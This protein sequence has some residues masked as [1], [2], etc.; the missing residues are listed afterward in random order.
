MVVTVP[1]VVTVAVVVS[2]DL[3]H[4]PIGFEQAHAQ[5]KRQRHI[6]L[7]RAQDA[8]I[9][10]DIAQLLFDLVQA[11]LIHKVRLVEHQDVAV[12]HL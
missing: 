9:V 7:H 1:M 11:T 12:N 4:H 2:L 10:L 6:P 3:V 5:Q 8:R